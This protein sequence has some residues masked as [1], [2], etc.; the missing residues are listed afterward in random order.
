[1]TS[2]ERLKSAAAAHNAVV[3]AEDNKIGVRFTGKRNWTYYWFNVIS[4]DVIFHH[5]YNQNTGR[6]KRTLISN[7]AALKK[8]AYF[9]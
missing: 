5:S 3:I 4:D 8:L 2:I 7:W 1:M 6:T 9:E